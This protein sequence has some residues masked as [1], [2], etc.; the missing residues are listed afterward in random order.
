MV[1]L[2]ILVILNS[3]PYHFIIRFIIKNIIT[4][5]IFKNRKNIIIPICEFL[6]KY[7]YISV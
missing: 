1:P 7:K 4:Y 2:I 3:K 5:I 6:R